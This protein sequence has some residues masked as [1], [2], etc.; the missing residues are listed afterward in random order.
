MEELEKLC[1][2]YTT[3]SVMIVV[4]D[5]KGTIYLTGNMCAICAK[6]YLERHIEIES[7][8]HNHLDDYTVN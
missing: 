3:Y 6:E 2:K 5:D 1:K 7:L 8:E 4:I